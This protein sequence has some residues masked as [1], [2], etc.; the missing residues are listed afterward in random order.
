MKSDPLSYKDE[1]DA[2]LERAADRLRRV[3]QEAVA[4]LDP[5]PPFPGSF[6]SYGIEIEA[7]GAE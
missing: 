4:R 3:L 1:A 7:P 2:A 6:V 5:F